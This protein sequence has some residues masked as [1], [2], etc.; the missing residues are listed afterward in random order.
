M[1]PEKAGKTLEFEIFFK[2]HK[3]YVWRWVSRLSGNIL[4]LPRC[5][6]SSRVEEESKNEYIFIAQVRKM[7]LSRLFFVK[8]GTFSPLFLSKNWFMFT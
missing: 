5:S 1:K 2:N 3:K 6:P 4:R 8:N 7:T